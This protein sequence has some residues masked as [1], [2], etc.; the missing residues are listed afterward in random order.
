MP[1]P[2]LTFFCELADSELDELFADPDV[3]D[4]LCI[5]D[6]RVSMGIV[7]LSETRARFVNRLTASGVPVVAWLLLPK[8]EGYWF[9]ASNT[10]EAAARWRE[11]STWT[12]ENGLAWDG[13][14]LD[15]EM[16]I[17]DL[18]SL[19]RDRSNIW[20]FLRKRLGARSQVGRA[21]QSYRR[22][23]ED[24]HAEGYEVEHY[25]LPFMLDERRAGSR[26][27]QQISG[28]VDVRGDRHIPML[29]TSFV[30]SAG[31]PGMIWSYGGEV[32]RFRHGLNCIL[33]VDAHPWV[34]VIGAAAAILLLWRRLRDSMVR[35]HDPEFPG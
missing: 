18:E 5:L 19:M 22:L 16:D 24:I 11:V 4:A 32:E 9:S 17:R 10:T 6:A 2:K 1:R 14:G 26:L 34:L 3:I 30:R 27:I 13:V 12:K 33:W 31:G 20:P 21:R 25:M 7:D 35:L 23:Y 15:A 29:Y 8:S 28:I